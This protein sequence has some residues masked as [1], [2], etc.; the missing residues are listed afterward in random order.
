MLSKLWSLKC[1]VLHN[2]SIQTYRSPSIVTTVRY[3]RTQWAGHV[4]R[5]G[6]TRSAQR[7]RKGTCP[8]ERNGSERMAVRWLTN[9]MWGWD[10][11]VNGLGM[12]PMAGFG[13]ELPGSTARGN[14]SCK[15]WGMKRERVHRG[16]RHCKPPGLYNVAV[17]GVLCWDDTF[18]KSLLAILS[19]YITELSFDLWVVY[20][21]RTTPPNY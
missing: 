21:L 13:V 18:R 17:P 9:K 3:R 12:F 4:F 20:I 11:D 10:L 15:V 7:I 14:T 2:D 6:E 5:K 1:T 19:I 16:V 8:E